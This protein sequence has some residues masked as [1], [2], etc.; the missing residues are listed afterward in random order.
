MNKK[1]H[2]ILIVDD[3]Q[4]SR[5]LLSLRMKEEGFGVLEAD[6]G[7]E[8]LKLLDDQGVDCIVVDYYMPKENGPLVVKQIRSIPQYKTIPILM[9]TARAEEDV[10]VLEAYRA[11]VDD[12]FNKNQNMQIFIERIKA[13]LN[14]RDLQNTLTLRNME[15]EKSI[16]ELKRLNETKDDFISNISHEMHTPLTIIREN[17]NILADGTAGELTHEQLKFLDSANRNVECMSAT[18]NDLLIIS[19]IESGAFPL[20]YEDI[21]PKLFLDDLVRSY[22]LIA[23]EK[24]LSLSNRVEGNVENISADMKRLTQIFMAFLRNALKFT[25]EKGQVELGAK[26]D[27]WFVVLWIRD[28]GPGISEEKLKHIFETVEKV[29]LVS[30]EGAK[31][32]SL[33][34]M[35]AKKLVEVHGGTVWLESNQGRGTTVFMRLPR[36][37]KT[38]ILFYDCFSKGIEESIQ[39]GWKFCVIDFICE[40]W[41]EIS[42]KYSKEI[43]SDFMEFITRIVRFHVTHTYDRVFNFTDGRIAV[44]LPKTEKAGGEAVVKKVLKELE[45]AVMIKENTLVKFKSHVSEYPHPSSG[46]NPNWA[47]WSVLLLMT[48]SNLLRV[49]NL[50]FE[51]KG[52]DLHHTTSC[53]EARDMARA[54]KY[55][56]IVLDEDVSDSVNAEYIRNLTKDIKTK[57][58]IIVLTKRNSPLNERDETKDR[59]LYVLQKPFLVSDIE[60]VIEEIHMGYSGS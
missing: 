6:S 21:S 5:H 1:K 4:D 45:S 18:I 19:K 7:S 53:E 52:V 22:T 43:L 17:I 15:M 42:R 20:Y 58:T 46:L 31:E 51:D 32:S 54:N 23:E 13:L 9:L 3:D 34:M 14:L 47:Y 59:S 25:P 50:V 41:D 11:G 36:V 48:D 55:K 12:F 27:G 44:L 56:I 29:S 38:E 8:A 39:T 30:S 24:G 10:L 16:G 40:G 2:T 60:W 49:W 37:Q 33:S 26:N 57:P 35:M 28:G